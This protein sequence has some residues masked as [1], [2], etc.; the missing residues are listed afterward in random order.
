MFGLV[1]LGDF[2]L[3]VTVPGAADAVAAMGSVVNHAP[4][5]SAAMRTHR[6]SISFVPNIFVP[7][8]RSARLQA[9]LNLTGRNIDGGQPTR[10]APTAKRRKNR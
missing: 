10:A 3:T 5:N 7:S 1:G 4:A 6:A 2:T 9:R 8:C